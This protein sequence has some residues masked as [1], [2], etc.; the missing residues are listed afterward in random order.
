MV[1]TGQDCSCDV[2]PSVC[3]G[4]DCRMRGTTRMLVKND[5]DVRECIRY[6]GL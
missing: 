2:D 1:H 3:G 6:G 5:G 4:L